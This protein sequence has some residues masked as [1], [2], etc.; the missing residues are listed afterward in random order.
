[1]PP[2]WLLIVLLAATVMLLGGGVLLYR[3]Q[4]EQARQHVEQHLSSISASKVGQISAWREERIEEATV[5]MGR[6]SFVHDLAKWL[7]DPANPDAPRALS[8]FHDLRYYSYDDIVLLDGRGTPRLSL[9][10]QLH[11][12]DA[13]ARDA[14]AA[15]RKSRTPLL[16]AWHRSAD[17]QEHIE[18]VAPLAEY[19]ED[20]PFIGALLLQTTLGSDVCNLFESWPVPSASGQILLV[21][22]EAQAATVLNDLCDTAP[23]TRAARASIAP[24]DVDGLI[25]KPG[26]V[27]GRDSRGVDVVSVVAQVPDSAW[28]VV[29]RQDEAEAFASSRERTRWL[30]GL[31]SGVLAFAGISVALAWQRAE[32]DRFR[33][34]LAAQHAQRR[35]EERHSTTLM[36]I[37]DAVLST[38]ADGRVDMLNPVAEALTGWSQAD[39]K[40]QPAEEVFR[41]VNEDTRAEVQSPIGRVLRE[42]KIVGLANHTLLISKSGGEHPI[43]DSGAPIYDDQGRVDG[44]VLVFRDQTEERRATAL[45][46]ERE[47][48]FRQLFT[49]SP[50]AELLVDPADG[51]IVDANA[52]AQQFYGWPLDELRGKQLADLDASPAESAEALRS[53]GTSAPQPFVFRHRTAKG[54]WRD[55]EMFAGILN[56]GGRDLLL[57]IVHDI[58]DRRRAE[59]A[60]RASERRFRTIYENIPLGV[61]QVSLD[62]KIVAA[63]P[64]YCRILG[65]R[66]EELAGKHLRDITQAAVLAENL[67]LQT[68]V[69]RGE[70]D[71]YS[72]EKGFTTKDGSEVRG[73]IGVNLVRDESGAPAYTLGTL[74]DITQLRKAELEGE[75]LR[76]QLVQAQKMESVGRLAGGVAHDF[77]NML[78]VI[79]GNAELA[80]GDLAPNDP[81]RDLIQEMRMAAERSAELT[82]QLLAFARK[83]TIAPKV[84]DLN[85]TVSGMLKMLA[86][87][88]GEDIKLS[89]IPAPDLWLVKV[90]PSQVDQLLAN[91]L[92]NARDAISGQGRVTIET[93]N[94]TLDDAFC[95]ARPGLAPGDFVRLDV[96]DTGSGMDES[97]ISHLF[98][99]FFTTKALGHGTGLGLATVYGIVQQNG[100]AIGVYSEPGK[101]TTFAVYLPRFAGPA[102]AVAPTALAPPR[103]TGQVVLLVED[104]PQLLRLGKRILEGLG[105][106]VVATE[107]PAR[108]PQLVEELGDKLSLVITDVVM[109]E[110]DGH[111]LIERI[112]AVR[113]SLKYLFMS[114]Y[115]AN[116]I[117][118]RGVLKDGVAFLQKPFTAADLAK[119]VHDVLS[120][121][122]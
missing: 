3:N 25:G 50:V 113:P 108:A 17:G 78:G 42:G 65:Y 89:W 43:A 100:G 85:Q 91:L 73:I 10:G 84:L 15:A 5:L 45:L 31:V 6:A 66:E 48:L 77:N 101:G 63:N 59:A 120:G 119:K 21:Q 12:P 121:E 82:R 34:L 56:V 23:S 94:A 49:D 19:G 79:L 55:V 57:S 97:T 58:S 29:T 111:Q 76:Q 64:A 103:G 96:T 7:E 107:S 67:D 14:V 28:Y 1:M 68:R 46:Q 47:R 105:Y 26:T 69:V 53:V 24:G 44:A 36:S 70:L 54:D 61:A 122:G 35:I 37:G 51:R 110:L 117:A 109:P 116:T 112:R 115:T 11:A 62:F 8:L 75:K 22:R 72:M 93:S 4:Q 90:D 71:S 102:K 39:A 98:E 88:I 2:R 83:Q 13:D 33:A 41:I 40:G 16:T 80:L 99:P 74:A 20:R 104:E 118:Q 18:A 60:L 32:K 27:Y 114:G 9:S 92:V 87:I 106:Q 30:F 95:Q 81:M 52:T 86:R 38:D